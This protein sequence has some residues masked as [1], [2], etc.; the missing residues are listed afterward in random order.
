MIVQAQ[1]HGQGQEHGLLEPTIEGIRTNLNTDHTDV[2]ATANGTGG[3]GG[4]G[5]VQGDGGDGYAGDGGVL[6][7]QRFMRTER[8]N[9]TANNVTM[10]SVGSA[11]AGTT[12]G[13]SFYSL[14]TGAE[15]EFFVRQIKS[16]GF[17]R[18]QC[19]G[20]TSSSA[21]MVCGDNCASV[22]PASATESAATTAGPPPLV[23]MARRSP[24]SAR[25]MRGSASKRAAANN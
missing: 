15:G 18:D 11:G 23:M 8:G 16:T 5:F 14:A 13:K 4:S 22:S 6:V 7:T 10:S 2:M 24:R 17:A 20:S 21:A 12:A 25:E 1:A 9:L 3:N 19:A